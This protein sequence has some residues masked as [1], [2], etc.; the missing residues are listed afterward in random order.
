M[1]GLPCGN[2]IEAVGGKEREIFGGALTV[3]DV[4]LRGG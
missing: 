3:G 2:H 1:C 4:C